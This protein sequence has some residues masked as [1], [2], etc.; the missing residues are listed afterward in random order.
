MLTSFVLY[1]NTD[2]LYSQKPS[3]QLKNCRKPK[4]RALCA[5]FGVGKNASRSA[6]ETLAGVTEM[7]YRHSELKARWLNRARC[8]D[9]NSHD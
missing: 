1:W 2:L 4:G 7:Q 3:W 5:M 8:R 6:L 9:E